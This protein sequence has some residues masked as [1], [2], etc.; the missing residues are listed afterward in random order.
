[1]WV[2]GGVCLVPAQHNDPGRGQEAGGLQEGGTG[3]GELLNAEAG[4]GALSPDDLQ[5]PGGPWAG[6]AQRTQDADTRKLLGAEPKGVAHPAP[7][8]GAVVAEAEG[9]QKTQNNLRAVLGCEAKPGATP[10]C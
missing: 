7:E 5:L 8:G 2:V 6:G 1:M 3:V 9:L 10:Q 4:G